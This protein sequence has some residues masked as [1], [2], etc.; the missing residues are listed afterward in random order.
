MP[1]T[2]AR[3]VSLDPR[4]A[5]GPPLQARYAWEVDGE[6]AVREVPPVKSAQDA[7]RAAITAG[8]LGLIGV[9]RVC[10]VE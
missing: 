6:V 2:E 4:L 3:P 7:V 9:R 8:S 10:G 5:I 1:G